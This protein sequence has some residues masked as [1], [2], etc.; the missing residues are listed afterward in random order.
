[1][2]EL[3]EGQPSWRSSVRA[4]QC[5]GALGELAGIEEASMFV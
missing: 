1:M 2:E 5:G 3:C 4:S